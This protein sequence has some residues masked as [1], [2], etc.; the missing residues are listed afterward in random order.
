MTDLWDESSETQRLLRDARAGDAEAAGRLFARYRGVL[1]RQIEMGLDPRVRKRSDASD[2][3]QETQLEAARRLDEFLT[4]R[5]VPLGLWLRR[6]PGARSSLST[7]PG[8]A[9]W[10]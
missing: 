6:I 8:D 7:A 10:T 4:H 1:R 5:P 2:I 3:V 9:A